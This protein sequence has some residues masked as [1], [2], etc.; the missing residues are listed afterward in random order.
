[1]FL[2]V[3]PD[4]RCD[5][6]PIPR[7]HYA[8]LRFTTGFQSPDSLHR[9]RRVAGRLRGAATGLEQILAEARE[10]LHLVG[11]RADAQADRLEQLIAQA[12]QRLEHLESAL[13]TSADHV[14]ESKP[15]ERSVSAAH[16]ED[17]VPSPAAESIVARI[18]EMANQG[19]AP[20]EIARRTGQHA[21]KVELILALRSVGPRPER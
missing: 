21:G 13:H 2:A 4:L 15:T 18:Y 9:D 7:V 19:L 10:L 14:I 1:M 20:I 11:Q 16:N 17:S 8:K 3:G 6:F 12:D 5:A